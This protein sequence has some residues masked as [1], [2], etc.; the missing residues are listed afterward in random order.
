[1]AEGGS[2]DTRRRFTINRR[3]NTP[4]LLPI[5][6][7]TVLLLE[8]ALAERKGVSVLNEHLQSDRYLGSLEVE[9]RIVENQ[10]VTE[11]PALDLAGDVY[12]TNI[13]TAKILKWNPNGKTRTELRTHSGNANGLRFAMNGDLLSC[14]VGSGRV[15]RTYMASGVISVLAEEYEGRGIQSPN[16]LDFDLGERIYFSSWANNP[17][18]AKDNLKAVYRIDPDRCIHQPL[19]ESEIHMPNGV[20]LLPNE[21]TLYLIEA[22]P[23][24]DR[25]RSILAFDLESN[26]SI[27]NRHTLA[28]LY[29]SRSGDGMCI[30]REGNLYFAP[31]LHNIRNDSG[32]LDT[33]LGIH[34]ISP[35]GILLA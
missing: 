1:M 25:N 16:D 19:S 15:T 4:S 14:E 30:D 28:N 26:G 23:S 22:H 29:P 18:L 13:P 34:V 31:G 7:L 3:F 32:T 11:G 35:E 33:R 24:D 20:V 21:K 27:S 2:R 10:V 6:S 12:F 17:D 5:F 9:T 8:I